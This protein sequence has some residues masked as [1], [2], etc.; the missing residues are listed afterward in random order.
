MSE[1]NVIA[2]IGDTL[3]KILW[4]NFETDAAIYPQII[5]SEDQI[6]LVSPDEMDDGNLKKLSLFLYQVI[7]NGHMKNS[8]MIAV[9]TA[10][11]QYPPLALDLLFLV[12]CSTDDRKKDHLLLGKVIQVFHDNAVLKGSVLQGGLAGSGEEFRLVFHTLP[13]EETINLW[14]SFRDKSF[15]LSVCYRVTPVKIDSTRQRGISRVQERFGTFYHTAV[16]PEG[17]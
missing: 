10:H 4:E 15:K 1:Y 12:T 6:T 14:Q 7:E 8:E 11:L 17:L 3:K 16:P 13:F 2:D 5:E 9:N